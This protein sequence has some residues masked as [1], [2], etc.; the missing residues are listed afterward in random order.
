MDPPYGKE[1]PFTYVFYDILHNALVLL[2][3]KK[4]TGEAAWKKCFV[5]MSALKTAPW[6]L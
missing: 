1:K 4:K 2:C 5:S 6:L 3:S